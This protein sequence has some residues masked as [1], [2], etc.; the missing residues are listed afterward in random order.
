MGKRLTA[1]YCQ[2]WTMLLFLLTVAS[3]LMFPSL[4]TA[5]SFPSAACIFALLWALMHH[6]DVSKAET[7]FDGAMRKED[8]ALSYI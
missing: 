8:T 1:I 2:Y 7:Q 4:L 6:M 3:S 5:A